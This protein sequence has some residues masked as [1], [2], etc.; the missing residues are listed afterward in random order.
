MIGIIAGEGNLPKVLIKKLNDKKLK[1]IVINLINKKKFKKNFYNLNISQF[2]KII[3]ILKSNKCKEVV[4]AGKVIRPSIK[5]LKFDYQ[6]LRLLPKIIASLRKGDSYALDLVIGILKKNNITVVSCIKY[7]PELRA[8]NFKSSNNA[9]RQELE[10]IKKGKSILDHINSKFDVGQSIVINNGFVVGIEAAEGT[11]EML[12]KSS[13]ILKKINKNKPSGIL[14]KM[15]K[16]IQDLRVDL[17]T[18][19]YKTIKKCIDIGLRGIALKKNANIFLDQ[20]KSL[21]L[22]KKNNFIIKV[23]N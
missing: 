10:D 18:I 19:G 1:F 8:E 12:S 17:P 15:P 3:S 16:K 23:I 5:D 22:I 4:L 21:K 7:L 13:S 11:D 2:S 9:S 14:I 6:M 20:D